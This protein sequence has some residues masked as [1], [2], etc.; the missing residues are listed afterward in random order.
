MEQANTAGLGLE[1]AKACQVETEVGLWKSRAGTEAAL[2]ES[3]KALE[4][5]RSTLVSKRNALELA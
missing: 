3:L 1:A 4:S 5:E 2:Q